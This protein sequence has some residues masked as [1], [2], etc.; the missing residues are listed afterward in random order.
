M[1]F[2]V[3][4]SLV[5]VPL[6][7]LAMF[8]WPVAFRLFMALCLLLG[9]EEYRRMLAF[10]GLRF[11]PWL[12]LTVLA[13]VLLPA[14]LGPD[15]LPGDSA[16]WLLPSNAGLALAGT[17]VAAALW[18]VF[19][20]DLEKGLPRFL[21]ELGGLVYLGLLGLSMVKLHALPD[22]AWWVLL[23]F[24]YA[25]V[26]DSG[27]LFAG[28]SFGRRRFNPLSP[29][30]TWEGFWGGIAVNAAASALV[31]PLFFPVGFPLSA[32]GFALLSVPA[33]VLGQGGDLFESMLKRYA[34]VKDSSHLIST[35]G[36]FLDKMDSALFVGPLVYLAAVLLLP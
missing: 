7:I 10:R 2:R 29:S 5:I 32:A 26:Y 4:S 13:A 33:S 9:Y 36:G 16:A 28:K 6:F 3:L 22:G 27:A 17:F 15:L 11:A 23:S 12:G 30:K 14:T 24:W 25:W 8:R 31:L 20:P 18:R 34:G 35:H 21:A 1:L 19:R